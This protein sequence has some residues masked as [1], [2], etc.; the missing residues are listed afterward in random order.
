MI[1]FICKSLCFKYY[2]IFNNITIRKNGQLRSIVDRLVQR[3]LLAA[4][5]L[6][7]SGM[8]VISVLHPLAE[9][10]AGVERRKPRQNAVTGSACSLCNRGCDG[11]AVLCKG[12]K[13]EGCECV[14]CKKCKAYMIR[15]NGDFELCSPR[16]MQVVIAR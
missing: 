12:R 1:K 6:E 2:M 13:G 7:K 10:K 15:G 8:P 9:G 14:F 3:V 11:S 4:D 5:V 16:A